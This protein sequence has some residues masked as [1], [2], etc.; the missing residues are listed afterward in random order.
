[1]TMLSSPG[2]VAIAAFIGAAFAFL[3]GYGIMIGFGERYRQEFRVRVTRRLGESFLFI[4][5]ERL[6]SLHLVTAALVAAIAGWVTG[7]LTIAVLVTVVLAVALPR[8]ILALLRRRRRL[9]FRDQVPD[10]AM[11]IAGGLRAGISLPQAIAQASA[12]LDSPARQELDLMIREQRLG[13]SFDVAL[14]GLERRM[15]GEEMALMAAALRIS[16]ATGG[17]LADTLEG[18]AESTRRKIALEG[19]IRAL[20]A[21]G[22]IQGWVMALLPFGVLILLFQLEPDA[23]A[24]LFTTSLG[25]GVCAFILV[26][27]AL[28]LF[29]VRR[30]VAIDI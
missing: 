20:T 11:L 3:V 30:I 9:A 12:E 6:L 19:K 4:D 24:T 22:R 25:L 17:N 21:Q 28:G 7:S 13:A 23:M 16:H 8:V 2:V 26:M 27:Q 29:F 15:P 1:M 10:A 5:A 14:S 18:L